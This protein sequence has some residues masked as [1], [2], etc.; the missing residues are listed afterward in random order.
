MFDGDCRITKAD[1]TAVDGYVGS[2]YVIKLYHD[3]IPYDTAIIIVK[4]DIDGDGMVSG[5]DL[6]RAKKLSLNMSA[7][8]YTEAGDVNADGVVN[9]ADLDLIASA[10]LKY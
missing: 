5:K 7:D 10:A 8:G 1:G 9:D 6:L 4:A 2:G 3:G